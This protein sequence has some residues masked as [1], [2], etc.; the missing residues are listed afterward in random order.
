MSDSTLGHRRS[1]NLYASREDVVHG[2]TCKSSSGTSSGG[3]VSL[4]FPHTSLQCCVNIPVLELGG[5]SVSSGGDGLFHSI[6]LDIYHLG[7]R[8]LYPDGPRRHYQVLLGWGDLK[9]FV[10][11]PFD[12]A[13]R[14]F[15]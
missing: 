10:T 1:E 15:A 8:C 14:T 4:P 11:G 13:S 12:M 9:L 3:R 2:S 6:E 7:I 5:T